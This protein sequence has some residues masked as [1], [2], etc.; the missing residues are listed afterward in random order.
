[1]KLLLALALCATAIGLVVNCG[2]SQGGP[3]SNQHLSTPASQTAVT[4]SN[5][6]DIVAT[7]NSFP[8]I[9]VFVALCDNVN[10]GI[11]PVSASLGNGDN[12]ATNLYWGAAFGVKTFFS[13]SKDWELVAESSNPAA[14]ILARAIFKKRDSDVFIVADA[15]RGKEISQAIWDFLEAASGKAGEEVTVTRGARRITFNS[16]G[17]SDLVVYVGHDGLMD[18][19]LESTP[20]KRDARKRK[21]IILACIS[22]KY[23]AKPLERTGADPLLWTTNLMAPEA[24]ILSAAID[25][26]L[27]QES[28][29]Q[30]RVRAAKAYNGYQNCGLKAASNLF[31]TGW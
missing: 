9:H 18:F 16:S 24:Y 4:T 28:D 27:K 17:S 30:I 23:F 21:A 13:R 19:T 22:K 14:G 3:L 15:Y 5:S 29:E 26:W 7:P 31:A 12:P 2:T 25:G 6:K 10:Q 11:V 8:V 20:E 1:M